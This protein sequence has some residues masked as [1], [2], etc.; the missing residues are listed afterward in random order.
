MTFRALGPPQ[1]ATGIKYA[2]GVS[3]IRPRGVA[4]E[5]GIHRRHRPGQ[6]EST[7]PALL[8]ARSCAA[9]ARH[10]RWRII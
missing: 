6:A 5:P 8:P 9:A 7:V 1:C 10:L 4:G 2:F 3:T